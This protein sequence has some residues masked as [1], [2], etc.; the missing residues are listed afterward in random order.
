MFGTRG[1]SLLEFKT[2]V[3]H[4]LLKQWAVH[5]RFMKKVSSLRP[6]LNTRDGKMSEK[7]FCEASISF[8][9]TKLMKKEQEGTYWSKTRKLCKLWNSRHFFVWLL[10]QIFRYQICLMIKWVKWTWDF[11]FFGAFRWTIEFFTVV[12]LA[13]KLLKFYGPKTGLKIVSLKPEPFWE[14]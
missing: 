9:F 4:V 14:A 10:P 11:N 2:R 8:R 13:K 6:K 7:V 1:M 12:G 3:L 5:Q